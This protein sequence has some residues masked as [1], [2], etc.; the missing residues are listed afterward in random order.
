MKVYE[1]TSKY[2]D[3]KT[4][5]ELCK[6]KD[7]ANLVYRHLHQ[8]HTKALIEELELLSKDDYF[9]VE[10]MHE[11]EGHY[12]LLYIDEDTISCFNWRTPNSLSN[13]LHILHMDH[14]IHDTGFKHPGLRISYRTTR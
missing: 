13:I 9:M 3:M 10:S 8:L 2:M 5:E 4:V 12:P 7:V 11:S 6:N 1:T 14:T